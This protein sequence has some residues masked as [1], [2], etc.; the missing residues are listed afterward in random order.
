MNVITLLY[1]ILCHLYGTV[2]LLGT[3]HG[4]SSVPTDRFLYTKNW[5]PWQVAVNSSGE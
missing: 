4:Y 2:S 3:E 1:D 5:F